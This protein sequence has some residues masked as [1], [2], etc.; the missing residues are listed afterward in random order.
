[1][2][3]ELVRIVLSIPAVTTVVIL[4]G[5]LAAS[6]GSPE[7]EVRQA[8]E[9]FYRALNTNFSGDA[10]PML[11]VWSHAEDVIE[12]S[13]YGGMQ[14]GWSAART[15]WE[16]LASA[17]SGNQV[18]IED[19]HVVA[20]NQFGVHVGYEKLTLHRGGQSVI[21]KIRVTNVFRRENGKWKIF[22]HHTDLFP[23]VEEQQGSRRPPVQG[24]ME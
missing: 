3:K 18:Q 2:S 22:A 14:V 16:Q 24:H 15:H 19:S 20:S 17:K 12:M 4:W 5:F 7:T 13:P 10:S 9:R 6:A 8:V 11:D 21:V 1:M 23:W